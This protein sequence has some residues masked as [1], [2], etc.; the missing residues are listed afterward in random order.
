MSEA[1]EAFL[2]R[3]DLLK[4]LI[5][6]YESVGISTEFMMNELSLTYCKL[7]DM[8]DE[9]GDTSAAERYHELELEVDAATPH[10]LFSFL[11]DFDIEIDIDVTD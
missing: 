1:E 6:Q 10:D 11:D 5:G 9:A 2:K 4:E 3:V 7:G 8:A